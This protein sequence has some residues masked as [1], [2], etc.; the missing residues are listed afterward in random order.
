MIIMKLIIKYS[1]KDFF[2]NEVYTEDIKDDFTKN[3]LVKAFLFLSKNHDASIQISNMVIFWEN[4]KNFK[5]KIV[6]ARFFTGEIVQGGTIEFSIIKKAWY[7]KL[8]AAV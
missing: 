7:D 5:N 4:M 6:S 2:N 3:D 8:R 1:R